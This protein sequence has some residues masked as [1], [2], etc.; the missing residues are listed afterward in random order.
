MQD[1]FE[2]LWDNITGITQWIEDNVFTPL[3]DQVY[4]AW[5]GIVTAINGS[6]ADLGDHL[7]W[8]KDSLEALLNDA[9]DGIIT[10]INGSISLLG[11]HINWVRDKIDEH[12]NDMQSGIV[13]SIDG[14]IALLGDHINWLLRQIRRIP[15]QWAAEFARGFERGLRE[16]MEGGS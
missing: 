16:E 14:S 2:D 3:Q 12:L 7:N 1:F 15:E 9:W 13:D 5:D 4:K 8:V 11:D 10:G 6:I